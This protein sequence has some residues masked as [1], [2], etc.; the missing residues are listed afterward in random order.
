MLV[1]RVKL[2][3]GEELVI[4]IVVKPVLVGLEARD[5]GVTRRRVMLRCMLA[6][7]SITA[8]DMPAFGTS[9]KMQPPPAGSRAFEAT[10][11]ARLCCRVDA[12]PL[13]CHGISSLSLRR[14]SRVLLPSHKQH[15]GCFARLR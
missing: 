13:R 5:D 6:R 10:R 11:S 4:A 3:T 2:R 14:R 12:I 9:A 15:Q 7:R 8:A 1:R